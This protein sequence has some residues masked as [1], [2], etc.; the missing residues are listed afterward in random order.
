MDDPHVGEDDLWD[1]LWIHYQ[2]EELR[3]H[4]RRSLPATAVRAVVM[5]L[6]ASERVPP[7]QAALLGSQFL[8]GRPALQRFWG[9]AWRYQAIVYWVLFLNDRCL[10]LAPLE[11][12]GPDGAVESP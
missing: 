12:L 5:A 3:V 2:S 10:V 6:L 4:H 7:L 8:G 1:V 9:T 11:P